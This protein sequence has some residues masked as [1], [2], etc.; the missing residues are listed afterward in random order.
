MEDLRLSYREVGNYII[1]LNIIMGVLF[2]SLPLITGLALGDRRRAW[3]GF[4]LAVIG[5]V[6]LGV[7]LSYPISLIFLLLIV[8]AQKKSVASVASP[9]AAPQETAKN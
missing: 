5:G 3:I 4:I 9:D 6:L 2:G 8:R 7:F 1:Y